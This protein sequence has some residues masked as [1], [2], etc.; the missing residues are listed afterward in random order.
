LADPRAPLE[1]RRFAE[2][3]YRIVASAEV[4]SMGAVETQVISGWR[5]SV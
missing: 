3:R 5:C 1:P 2:G 4:G